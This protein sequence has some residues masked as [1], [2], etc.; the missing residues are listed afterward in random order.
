MRFFHISHT[1]LDGYG[2]QLVSS[3]YFPNGRYFN[4]NYG[5]E[6]KLS[7]KAVLEEVEEFVA[8]NSDEEVFILISDLGL[9]Y[10]ESKDLDKQ[11]NRLNG[12]GANIRLQ[13]LDHHISGQKSANKFKWYYLDTNRSAVKIV[14]D[15]FNEE[16]HDETKRWLEP[17]VDAINA[18]DIWKTEEEENFEFGKVCMRLVGKASEINHI[19]FADKNRDYRLSLLKK[20]IEFKNQENGHIKLDDK[21]H[22]LKKEYLSL[23][24][25]D[26]TID[27]LSSKYLVKM[28]EDKKEELT[29]NYN[30]HKGLLTFTLGSISIP[31]NAFLVAN[32]DYDFFIDIGRRGNAS[33]RADGK[34]DVSELAEKL[35]GGGGHKNAAG[36]R[37][38]DFVET[39]HY[40]EVKKFIQEKLDKV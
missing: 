32:D 21:I 19:L 14:Y 10:N 20:A 18:V 31:A 13:L 26:D 17:L 39:I 8:N 29:V 1:D 25:K 3:Q 12:N 23:D 11:I 30:G 35:A 15:F 6:V 33:F 7:I 9:T 28:L 22:F 38:N 40:S 36:V 27:N 5:L 34:V 37:F 4:A 2:C 24:G 16:F